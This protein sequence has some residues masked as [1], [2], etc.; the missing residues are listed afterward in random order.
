MQMQT[1]VWIRTGLP[2]VLQMKGRRQ[3][4][5]IASARARARAQAWW[6]RAAHTNQKNDDVTQ[7]VSHSRQPN[8]LLAPSDSDPTHLC[9]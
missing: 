1:V 8:H 2:P 5:Q 6:S 9:E 4:C 3:A 7:C